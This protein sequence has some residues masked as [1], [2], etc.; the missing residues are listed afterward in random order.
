MKKLN[1]VVESL[2]GDAVETGHNTRRIAAN[3]PLIERKLDILAGDTVYKL[4]F[5]ITEKSHSVYL[6][7]QIKPDNCCDCLPGA[8]PAKR[9]VTAFPD[10]FWYEPLQIIH[11]PSGHPELDYY[12]PHMAENG[13]DYPAYYHDPID[14]EG[15]ITNIWFAWE[16]YPWFYPTVENNWDYGQFALSPVTGGIRVPVNGVYSMIFR[17]RAGGS[18]TDSSQIVASIKRLPADKIAEASNLENWETISRKIY[19]TAK[20]NI[21]TYLPLSWAL[22]WGWNPAPEDI[23]IVG[24]GEYAKCCGSAGQ[25]VNFGTTVI[26][27]IGGL[28]IEVY[29]Y[30]VPLNEGDIIGG[31]LKATDVNSWTQ[32]E[33]GADSNTTMID[34]IGLGFGALTGKVTYDNSGQ[35]LEGV[36][37]VCNNGTTSYSTLTNDEGRYTF[38]DLTPDLTYTVT[39]TK[40]GY[41]TQSKSIKVVF[42][43]LVEL[44]FIML[45]E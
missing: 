27:R 19:S 36:T 14:T 11:H 25:N 41:I 12:P 2:R 4:E 21:C 20:G 16:N 34:L 38:Y 37:V 5:P 23:I 39:I 8:E 22:I 28:Y 17:N 29:A 40:N 10:Y 30:C 45:H 26:E 15:S 18:S 32:G 43:V 7:V 44:D 6:N 9:Y 1:R 24:G 13:A 31:W 42:N 33:G 35:P 3:L